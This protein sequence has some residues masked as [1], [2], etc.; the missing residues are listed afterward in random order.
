VALVE[1]TD[2]AALESRVWATLYLVEKGREPG[3]PLYSL[4]EL[5]ERLEGFAR[6]QREERES[7]LST[8]LPSRVFARSRWLASQA[9]RLYPVR[10]TLHSLPCNPPLDPHGEPSFP[11]WA[12][13]VP[14]ADQPGV[15]RQPCGFEH[16]SLIDG[17]TAEDA[18]RLE[19]LRPKLLDLKVS[20]LERLADALRK[21]TADELQKACLDQIA[22]TLCREELDLCLSVDGRY[23]EVP[24]KWVGLAPALAYSLG[25]DGF[26]P[27]GGLSS[28]LELLGHVEQELTIGTMC[29]TREIF[30][31]LVTVDN[32]FDREGAVD[33]QALLELDAISPYF[34]LVAYGAQEQVD[35]GLDTFLRC[36]REEA[37][38]WTRYRERVKQWSDN[39]TYEDLQLRMKVSRSDGPRVHLH[40]ATYAEF[41]TD[42]L[43]TAGRLPPIDLP[44]SEELSGFDYVFRCDGDI[45][46][47]GDK[48]KRC[49]MR[50][51]KG[52][53]YLAI[54]LRKQQP[55]SVR[56][57]IAD[58]GGCAPVLEAPQEILDPR[59]RRE[60]IQE[61]N[62]LKQIVSNPD[63][64]GIADPGAAEDL[65]HIQRELRAASHVKKMNDPMERA[66][67]SVSA[68]ISRAIR[69][70]GACHE[71]LGKHFLGT[72]NSGVY[73]S[74]TPPSPHPRWLL[75]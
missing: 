54:L 48:Q 43:K 6:F 69:E 19:H 52:L 62:R 7:L 75:T 46:V 17:L 74:Y 37:E 24:E 66:R 21:G 51:T 12:K 41:A 30:G 2:P 49:R 18:R 23:V 60:L 5:A 42:C 11:T 20:V 47:I 65:A 73:C 55:V 56:D 61:R 28:V 44:G 32:D 34:A 50:D 26:I 71:K 63:S 8:G 68:C 31:G 39:E 15:Q 57:L 53:R 9:S 72:I 58:V 14:F 16:A 45:W 13:V 3:L 25:Y 67:K 40:M 38:F 33:D 64:E 22:E 59:A 10:R 27:P 70:I 36:D 29:K 35:A 1:N 4:D